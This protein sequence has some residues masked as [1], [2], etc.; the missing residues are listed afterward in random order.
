STLY[1]LPSTLYP[2]P[3]TLVLYLLVP[4]GVMYYLSL[5]RPMYNPKFLL[6][7]TP[8]FY[9]LLGSGV[10]VLTEAI[11]A[12]VSRSSSLLGFAR[13]PTETSTPGAANQEAEASAGAAKL[14]KRVGPALAAAFVLAA[15]AATTFATGR[16]LGAYYFDAKYARDD[17]RGLAGYIEAT[18]RPGDAIVL[19]APSQ[20]EIFGYY[21]KGPLPVLPIPAQRP[22]DERVTADGLKRAGEQYRRIWVVFWAEKESDPGGFV[23]RWLNQNAFRAGNRWYGNVRLVLYSLPTNTTAGTVQQQVDA[24]FGDQISLLGFSLSGDRAGQAYEG[25]PG[26]VLQ[27]TLFWRALAKMDQRYTVFTHLLDSHEHIWGQRDAEPGSGAKPTTGWTPGAVISDN[28]GI[29]ILFGTP[30]GDY[31]VEAGVYLPATGQRLPV[32][33]PAGTAV[34][35]RVL[36]GPLRVGKAD[37]PPPIAS[38]NAR[39]PAAADFGALRLVGYDFGRLGS[40]QDGVTFG[41][42]DIARLALYWQANDRPG[43]DH[44]VVVRLVDASGRAVF[45]KQNP[46]ADGNYPTS[47]WDKGEIVLDQ[48]KLPLNF[49]PGKYR[50][51]VGIDDGKTKPADLRE[52]LTGGK[53]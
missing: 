14:A 25:R 7:A 11:K 15:L 41:Q 31:Y 42:G 17:Y 10:I 50:L 12:G 20:S 18:S 21:Y 13:P 27:L 16:S 47:R 37:A 46:P 53:G 49:P 34:G 39:F 52:V 8:P 2:L 36:F 5:S 9:L 40:E 26:E 45:T 33:A 29:P 22:L 6:V 44:N 19:N 28:Y 1:P 38:L 4:I 3:S 30:P 32:Q 35:D 24:N 48:H 51:T 23:E 43:K